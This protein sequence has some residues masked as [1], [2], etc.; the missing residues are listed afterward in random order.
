MD[1]KPRWILYME[2]GQQ[3]YPINQKDV[4]EI[5]WKSANNK[6]LKALNNKLVKALNSL[7]KFNHSCIRLHIGV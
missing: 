1:Y 5:G 2:T 3:F 4:L 6:L 7:N